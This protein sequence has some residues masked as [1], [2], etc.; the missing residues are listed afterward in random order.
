[1]SYFAKPYFII[2]D[3]WF[4]DDLEKNKLDVKNKKGEP[5]LINKLFTVEN[6]FVIFKINP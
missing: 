6:N 4:D 1:L 3:D 2:H 5:N